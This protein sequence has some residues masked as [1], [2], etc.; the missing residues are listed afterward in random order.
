MAKKTQSK[1]A[2]SRTAKQRRQEQTAEAIEERLE[3]QQRGMEQEVEQWDQDR[4][5]LETQAQAAEEQGVSRP[6]KRA[7]LRRWENL[8]QRKLRLLERNDELVR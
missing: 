2:P 4:E 3:Q 8:A 7:F 1:S 5:S 6:Q